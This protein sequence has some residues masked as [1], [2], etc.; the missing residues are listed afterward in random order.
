MDEDNKV[1][2][3]NGEEVVAPDATAD[4]TT[5][6]ADDVA[7][8]LEAERKARQK[9]EELANNYKVRAEKAEKTAKVVKPQETTQGELSVRDAIVLAKSN[10]NEEDLDEVVE[11]AKFKK[12]PIADALKHPVMKATLDLKAETRKTAQA[13]S[14]GAARRS[15]AKVS[16][17]T[18]IENAMKGRLPQ[19]D[20]EMDALV[21]ARWKKIKAK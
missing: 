7:S 9:A 10:V 14:T 5:E 8:Q 11:F 6:P 2:P 13:T 1:T 17:D 19:T 20:D 15:S 12:I 18:I 16:D 4:D 21:N 3:P